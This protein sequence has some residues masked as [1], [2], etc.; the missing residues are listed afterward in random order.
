[1][2]SISEVD[3]NTAS[4][5]PLFSQLWALYKALFSFMSCT[6]LSLSLDSCY[7]FPFTKWLYQGK[8]IGICIATCA[9]GS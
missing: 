7:F 2:K 6:Y 3:N 9:N 8:V 1:M 4:E 5:L